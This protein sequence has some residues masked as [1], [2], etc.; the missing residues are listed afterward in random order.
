MKKNTIILLVSIFCY[1][2]VT[3]QNGITLDYNCASD[4]IDL[5]IN[6]GESPYDVVWNLELG[7]LGQ[8]FQVSSL[9]GDPE[10]DN[11]RED[12][13]AIHNGGTYT[14]IVTDAFCGVAEATLTVDKCEC[15][16]IKLESFE[17]VSEC[18]SSS[19]EPGTP[20]G[21]SSACDGSITIL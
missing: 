19:G 5:S 9:T 6:G 16:D 3:A 21:A 12:L 11:N 8:T 7:Q 13:C 10:E 2:I 1:G 18:S 14:A 15:L 20:G 4:C 17:N